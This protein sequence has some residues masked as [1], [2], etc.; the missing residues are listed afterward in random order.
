MIEIQNKHISIGVKKKGAELSSI[1]SKESNTE[2][3]W[4][5]HPDHWGRHSCILFPVIGCVIDDSII[6][7]DVKY[8]MLKHGILRD[9]EFE[10][11]ERS[12]DRLVFTMSSDADTL[13]MYPFDFTFKAIYTLEE[14]ICKI[15]YEVST[16]GVVPIPFNI[17]GHPAFNCP[18]DKDKKR[19][20]YSLIFN[21][22]EDQSSPII[23]QNGMISPERQLVLDN[24]KTLRITDELFDHD[25]LILEDTKSHQVSLVDDHG[26]VKWTFEYKGFTHLGIWSASRTAP[27]VCIEPWYG[28]AAVQGATG[29]Y[30]EKKA[31]QWVKPREIWSCEH[32]V[33]IEPKH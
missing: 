15:R 2:Y 25:A 24:S 22:S 33:F 31:I 3:L 14:S 8:P 18:L 5:A 16:D 19:S 4:Q 6:I 23:D 12:Q 21:E 7:D 20:D 26:D 17:G 29:V 9:R 1:K 32:S 10:L 13:K 27:F 28:V 11:T 30:V